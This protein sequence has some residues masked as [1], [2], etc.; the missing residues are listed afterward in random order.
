VD[1]IYEPQKPY[2]TKWR[3]VENKSHVVISNRSVIGR[4]PK[5]IEQSH[6]VTDDHLPPGA[7]VTP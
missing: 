3:L 2:F 4:R 7:V 1:Q 5:P 6:H